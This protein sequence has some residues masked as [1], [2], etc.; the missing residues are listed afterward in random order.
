MLIQQYRHHQTLGVSQFESRDVDQQHRRATTD[1]ELLQGGVVQ[2]PG[3]GLDA[4][5]IH[6]DARCPWVAQAGSNA[7]D[8]AGMATYRSSAG[9]AWLRHMPETRLRSDDTAGMLMAVTVPPAQHPA[10]G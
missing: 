5:Q 9:T 4:Q 2:R 10:G 7:G 6:G 8:R 3:T 1:F